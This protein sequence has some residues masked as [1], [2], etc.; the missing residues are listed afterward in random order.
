M[1]FPGQFAFHAREWTTI[2]LFGVQGAAIRTIW[3]VPR[4]TR[5]LKPPIDGSV[6]SA[7]KP[8]SVVTMPF[9]WGRKSSSAKLAGASFI[10]GVSTLQLGP[11]T[12]PL[13]GPV[14]TVSGTNYPSHLSL[15]VNNV[16]TCLSKTALLNSAVNAANLVFLLAV[17]TCLPA[18]YNIKVSSFSTDQTSN[19]NAQNS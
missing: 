15:P 5:R 4:V 17:S 14:S 13:D 10:V 11:I 2:R 8:A 19:S 16:P 9:H 6:W 7:A 3:T 18:C 12:K 1:Y